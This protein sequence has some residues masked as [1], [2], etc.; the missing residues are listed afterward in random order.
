METP[1]FDI[2]QLV[3]SYEYYASNMLFIKTKAGTLSALRF[4][5]AQKKLNRTI[6]EMQSKGK[7]I[8]IIVLKARQEGVSTFCEG[9]IF[10]KSHFNENNRSVIIAHEIESGNQIFN[11][12]KLFYDCIPP[13]YRP[14][15]KYSSRKEIVFANPDKKTCYENPGMRS[16]IEVHTA[17]KFNVGRG[18]T[19]HCLHA[20]ELASWTFPEDTVPALMPTI[21]KTP[22]S[23]VIFEST[24]S[25]VGGFFHTE[26]LRAKE[27]ESNFLPFFLA[28]F[29]LEEY[30]F[31][32]IDEI[33]SKFLQ[34]LNNEEKELKAKHG[35][36]AEQ[37]FWRRLQIK[38]LSGDVEL[39]RQEYPANDTEA[40]IVSGAPVFDRRILREIYV[41]SI[42]PKTRAELIKSPKGRIVFK[43]R[44]DGRLKMWDPPRRGAQYVIGVDVGGFTEQEASYYG[45]K[46]LNTGDYTCAQVMKRLPYPDIAEQVCEWHGH[47][48]HIQF[49][50]QLKRLAQMYN[51]AMVAIE[52]ESYGLALQNEL[53]RD[54]YNLYQWQRFD[55]LKNRYTDK[56]GWETNLRSKGQLIAFGTH[57]IYEGSAIVH[58]KDLITEMMTYV[59]DGATANAASG[60]DDRV[61]AWMIGLFTLHQTY[62]DSDPG[63]YKGAIKANPNSNIIV[64]TGQVRIDPNFEELFEYGKNDSYQQTWLDF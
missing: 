13:Q 42:E 62:S 33:K 11:M 34:E 43:R 14:M 17:G 4:N 58:S 54:Y 23:I 45:R 37:L 49:A 16:S 10:H 19:I 51:N 18:S 48:D 32:L 2:Q 35:L 44:E 28:W 64:P 25:G 30:T 20:S 59:K 8:R 3:S 9:F 40:F 41:R 56:I 12:C 1:Q 39:F 50:A 6:L 26:W 27:G 60:Y 53:H 21:P 63:D 36:T 61:M 7:L 57:C 38:D 46:G 24:A 29:D 22:N 52:V 15:T 47:V 31:P 5:E 55:N